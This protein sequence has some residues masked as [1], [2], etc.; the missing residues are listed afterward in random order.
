[1]S[2]QKF[3]LL[4][5]AIRAK[6]GTQEAFADAMEMRI[7]TLSAKL[8]GRSEWT[9]SQIKRACEL[10]DIPLAEVHLYFFAE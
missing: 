8:N 9:K 2:K 3:A 6:F 10:L 4:R 7:S 1:M 5:G